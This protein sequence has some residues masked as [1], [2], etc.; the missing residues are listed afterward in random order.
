MAKIS[1]LIFWVFTTCSLV[2]GYQHFRGTCCLHLLNMVI[3]CCSGKMA[4]E[5]SEAVSKIS[6][7][8]SYFGSSVVWM[9]TSFFM[10][11]CWKAVWCVQNMLRIQ[12]TAAVFRLCLPSFLGAFAKLRKATISFVM[13]G[14]PSAWN[15]SAPTGRIFM[16]FDIWVFFRKSVERIQFSLKSDKNNGTLHEGQYIFDHTSLSSS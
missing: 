4:I 13:S 1:S 9:R 2:G 14:R 12:L 11:Q 16:K 8:W 3:V 5:F 6:Y 15:K 7:L 10:V